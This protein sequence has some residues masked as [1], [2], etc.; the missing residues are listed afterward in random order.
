VAPRQQPFAV[1]LACADSRVA[2]ELIFDQHLGDLFVCRVAG[3]V[4]T[5]EVL[6]SIE[7][8][9]ANFGCSLVVVL[10][11]QR[12]GAVTDTIELVERGGEAP[13]HV[14]SIVDAIAPI[15]E[16]SGSVDEAV[17]ANAQAS[18]AAIRDS[19]IVRDALE[20]AALR[21]VAAEYELDSG[22]VSLLP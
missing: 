8:A 20:S 14:Q 12:C 4:V 13:G 6:G 15:V 21:V 7:Y 5:P 16:P 10:G 22:L 3:N 18:A 17:R 1:V 2:P 11:H 19:A 9:V